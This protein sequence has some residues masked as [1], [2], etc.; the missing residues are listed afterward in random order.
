MTEVSK[1]TQMLKREKRQEFWSKFW[2][3]FAIFLFWL[4]I[5]W[6]A[7]QLISERSHWDGQ[8]AEYQDPPSVY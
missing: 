6:F 1:V 2:K 4:I 3:G 5:I 7:T 8:E